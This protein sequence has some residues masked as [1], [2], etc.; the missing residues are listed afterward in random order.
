[1]I[2]SFRTHYTDGNPVRKDWRDM[3]EVWCATVNKQLSGFAFGL[4]KCRKA[5]VLV[6]DWWRV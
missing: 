1:M 5:D 3:I 4:P 2:S 6:G